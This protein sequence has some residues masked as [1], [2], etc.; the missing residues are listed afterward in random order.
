MALKAGDVAAARRLLNTFA[1]PETAAKI[2]AARR[3]F[4]SKGYDLGAIDTSP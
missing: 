3:E 1:K 2:A 4:A